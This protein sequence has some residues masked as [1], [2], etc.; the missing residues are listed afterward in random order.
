MYKQI[1]HQVIS[2]FSLLFIW[3][4]VDA[5]TSTSTPPSFVE[6]SLITAGPGQALYEKFGHS[7]IRVKDTQK[8]TDLIYNYGI[9]D[10]DAPNFYVNFILGRPKYKV[11]SYPFHYFIKGYQQENRWV[12][13]QIL[14][15]N[16]LQKDLIIAYLNTN[17]LPENAT[18]IYDPFF[19]NCSTKERDILQK[20]LNSQVNFP[21]S[22]SIGEKSIRSLMLEELHWNTWGAFGINVALGS[23]LD[24]ERKI[25]SYSYLPDY[26]FSSFSNASIKVDKTTNAP[27][28]KEVK[29]LLDFKEKEFVTRIMNP[30]LILSIL[31]IIVLFVIFK[32]YKNIKKLRYFDI[33]F[34]SILGILGIL[35]LFLWFFTN[36]TMSQYN[37]NI[38]WANPLYFLFIYF[39][40]KNK[41]KWINKISILIFISLG[42]CI[43]LSVIRI[44]YLPPQCFLIIP[45][46]GIRVI[47]I[48]KN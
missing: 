47:A 12:K 31:L 39:T 27:L 1:L 48:Y 32:H 11:A 10:F 36:H 26:L 44:Q 25:S 43:L 41:K 4:T 24:A 40:L 16:S 20:V 19:D 34:F 3:N 15:L 9:F 28:V 46:I 38:L 14:Q 5:Q 37:Y 30:M 7:A 42:L 45:I 18:Y 6:I 35:L 13:E 22:N 2:I 23:P 17:I 8:K 29:T 21:N 33:V